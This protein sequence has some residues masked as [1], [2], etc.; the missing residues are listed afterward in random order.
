MLPATP[1]QPKFVG[2]FTGSTLTVIDPDT[3]FIE[4]PDMPAEVAR[5]RYG[6]P[7]LGPISLFNGLKK[8]HALNLL[9]D[10]WPDITKV[11]ES[12]GISRWTFTNHYNADEEF[13]R[14]V[15]EIKDKTIDGGHAVRMRVMMKDSGSFDRMC[16]LNAY[17][18]E[19]YNPK[20]KIEV[21]HTMQPMEARRR[22]SIIDKVVDAE[23]VESVKRVRKLKTGNAL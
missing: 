15:D 20:T 22:D 10:H 19:T 5:L 13:R 7:A 21:E 9:R 8:A 4:S 2:N 1:F 14:C 16:V 17:M 12:L 11:C 6:N 18:P 23:I 3:G